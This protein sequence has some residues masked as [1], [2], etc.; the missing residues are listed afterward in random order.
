MA[1][2]LKFAGKFSQ[3]V[4]EGVTY[5]PD[6]EGNVTVDNSAH[7]DSLMRMGCTDPL[8]VR[9]MAPARLTAHR[10]AESVVQKSEEAVASTS[11][12]EAGNTAPEASQALPDDTWKRNDIVA[13][14]GERGV[15]MHPTVTKV[16]ALAAVADYLEEHKG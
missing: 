16:V 4:V 9:T 11:V 15:V 13:W 10:P 5:T 1:T 2:K 14:L 3:I 12:S 7:L 6:A 8:A